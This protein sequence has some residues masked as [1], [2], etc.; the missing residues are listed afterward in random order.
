MPVES[1][2]H[3]C[4]GFAVMRGERDGKTR[5]FVWDFE[6]S[7]ATEK[8]ARAELG[9]GVSRYIE[10]ASK[11]R[12]RIEGPPWRAMRVSFVRWQQE[13]RCHRSPL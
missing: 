2:G 7:A 5:T 10:W 3:A 6:G 1:W 4:V 11:D 12:R 9:V 8:D 13:P